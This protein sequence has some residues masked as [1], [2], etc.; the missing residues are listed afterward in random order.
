[1]K[2][3]NR[4]FPGEDEHRRGAD[5]QPSGNCH[6][7][8]GTRHAPRAAPVRAAASAGQAVGAWNPDTLW[9]ER[10]AAVEGSPAAAQKVRRPHP[11]TRQPHSW[12]SEKRGHRAHDLLTTCSSP[13]LARCSAR[14]ASA[15]SRGHAAEPPSS[16]PGPGASS[17][18]CAGGCESLRAHPSGA[19][20]PLR[21]H[22]GPV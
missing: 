22:G 1:M 15:R 5:G 10:G 3:T 16:P 9:A 7:T 12:V 4:R 21:P 13:R 6:H 8:R 17:P 18:V 2:D 19:Q 14:Q 11:V 20:W